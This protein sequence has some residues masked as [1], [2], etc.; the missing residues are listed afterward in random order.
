MKIL[1]LN[2]GSSSIKYK[3]FEMDSKEVLAQGGIERIGLSGAFLKFTPSSGEKVILEREIPEHT[4]GIEFILE[5]LTSGKYGCIASLDEI[6]AVGHRVVHGGEKFNSSVLITQE[7]IDQMVECSD[8]APLH[9]PANLKGIHTISKLLPS[10]PQVGVFDTAF[11]QTMPDYAYMYAIPYELYKKYAVRRY[12]FHGTSHRYVSQRV[13][14]F[15]GVNIADQRIITC[16]IGNGGSI[17]AIKSGKSVDTSMGLTPVEG[18]M[19]GT[20][21]GDVDAGVLTFLMEKEKLDAQG[22]SDLLNKKSGVLGVFGVSSDMRELEKAVSE[23]KDKRAMLADKMYD[24]RIKKYIGAYAAVL[25]GVDIIVFTGGVGE[26]QSTCRESVCE[27]LE[28][29]GV[30]LDK[31]LN[32]KIHGTE[33]VISTPD[34]KVKVVVIPTDEELTIA[35]DTEELLIFIP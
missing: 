29:M 13:C 9:N 24:Y 25:G 4:V 11:H 28:Y 23:G 17:T 16:H 1:V 26:N 20:R 31:E 8:L 18:L 10:V 3:L 19:M 5:I 32:A 15:L 21:S 30:K 2:C 34:S 6:A 7:V 27:G 22:L 35:M 33:T 14:D 12:G